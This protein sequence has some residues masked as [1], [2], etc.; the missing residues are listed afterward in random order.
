M[1]TIA[2]YY[3]HVV[4]FLVATSVIFTVKKTEAGVPCAESCVWIPCTVTALLGCSCKDKV[5]YLNH[6]IAFEAKTMDEHH[7][8]C[9]SH[10]DCYK[11]GSGNF[12]APFFNH[13]VKYG[14]CF[15][16]EFEGYLLKDFLKMQPR[17][18]LKI[19]KAIAK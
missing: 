8:L 3:A 16:A 4:L 2:R 17:D 1:G 11:K 18:I 14:W 13:D 6:V 5:C 10:E 7:L 19:S 9:Q 12:C 15:R